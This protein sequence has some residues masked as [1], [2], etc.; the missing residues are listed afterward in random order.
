VRSRCRAK[1]VYEYVTAVLDLA[2]P[3]ADGN[4]RV[5]R[6]GGELVATASLKIGGR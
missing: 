2:V 3:P 4:L 6:D 1:V 5:L